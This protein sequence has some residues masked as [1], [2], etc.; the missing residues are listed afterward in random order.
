M[1]AEDIAIDDA[2]VRIVVAVG[3]SRSGKE[4]GNHGSRDAGRINTDIHNLLFA[5][6]VLSRLI[7]HE[8]QWLKMVKLND[9]TPSK[10]VGCDARRTKKAECAEKGNRRRNIER[11]TGEAVAG[12]AWIEAC[13][14][15]KIARNLT[16]SLLLVYR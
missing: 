11:R 1:E 12:F 2:L 16:I 6:C 13:K 8:I 3:E 7:I 9:L 4:E 14:W 10:G 5:L 15:S